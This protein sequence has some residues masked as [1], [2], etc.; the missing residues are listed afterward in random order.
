MSKHNVF[1]GAIHSIN[2][3]ALM[4]DMLTSDLVTHPK[5]HV[6]DLH[7]EYCQIPKDIARQTCTH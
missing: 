4:T 3:A 6:S 5:E 1:Y 7:E 2:T